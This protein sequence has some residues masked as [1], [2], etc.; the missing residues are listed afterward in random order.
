MQIK[1]FNATANLL[2]GCHIHAPTEG[3]RNANSNDP[4]GSNIWKIKN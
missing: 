1:S 3:K 4:S 2:S